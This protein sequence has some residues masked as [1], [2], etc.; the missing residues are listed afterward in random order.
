MEMKIRL[1]L[2]ENYISANGALYSNQVVMTQDPEWSS[3]EVVKITDLAGKI[4]RLP[5]KY[6]ARLSKSH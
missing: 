1:K 2:K 5:K 3:K 6:L 4:Y